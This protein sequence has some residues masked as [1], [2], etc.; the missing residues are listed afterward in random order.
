VNWTS[1]FD[2][3]PLWLRARPEQCGVRNLYERPSSSAPTAGQR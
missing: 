2:V 3:E 1:I